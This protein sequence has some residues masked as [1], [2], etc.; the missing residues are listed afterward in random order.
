LQKSRKPR[1]FIFFIEDF[2]NIGS[3]KAM[4]KVLERF[5]LKS[6]HPKTYQQLVKL[7]GWSF[8]L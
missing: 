4:V 5:F 1:G 7:A 8:R 2:L 6:R 3:A